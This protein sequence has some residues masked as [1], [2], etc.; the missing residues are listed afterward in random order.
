M[1]DNIS[2]HIM[3]GA[4]ECALWFDQALVM[5]KERWNYT[6]D[7]GL[8]GGGRQAT[9]SVASAFASAIGWSILPQC[10]GQHN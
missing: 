3:A 5:P 1:S 8:W 6:A 7:G 2:N 4:L 10:G 9:V